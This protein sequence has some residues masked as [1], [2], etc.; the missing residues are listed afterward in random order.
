MN[1]LH[2]KKVAS[3]EERLVEAQY[4]LAALYYRSNGDAQHQQAFHLL[5]QGAQDGHVESIFLLGQ[6]HWTG[7][8]CAQPNHSEAMTLWKRIALRH[9]DAA[10]HLAQAYEQS[11]DLPRYAEFAFE[12]FRAASLRN[13]PEGIYRLAQC[14]ELGFGTRVHR[15]K[16][17]ETYRQVI[18]TH[19][20][21]QACYHCS[22]LL[23]DEA[24]H[25][26]APALR[27]LTQAARRNVVP[28]QFALAVCYLRGQ[29]VPSD[30]F[31]AVMWLKKAARAGHV[32]SM[33]S[34][35]CQY[36]HGEGVS[37]QPH[38]A[39]TLFQQAVQQGHPHAAGSV[40]ICWNLLAQERT[41]ITQ[42][43]LSHLP[44]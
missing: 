15:T 41:S 27:L 39:L 26:D 17:I 7:T 30:S 18:Q 6:C 37:R 32:Y 1:C 3:L 40:A 33:H 12:Y 4:A 19:Q 9:G 25:Y 42:S 21:P 14:Y 36:L 24:G 2:D 35:A 22:Q 11:P 31:V 28:A 16:A 29:G 10:F 23:R 13:H 20:H 5:T 34:L 38:K 43:S 44:T 8:G